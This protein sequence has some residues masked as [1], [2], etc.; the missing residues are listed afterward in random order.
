MSNYKGVMHKVLH[1]IVLL[2]MVT[3]AAIVSYWAGF[4]SHLFRTAMPQVMEPPSFS[5]QSE[6]PPEFM[7]YWEAW[8][9]IQERF[10]GQL[11]EAK[12]Q[13]YG[14]IRGMLAALGDPHT[15]FI[16]PPQREIE[17][18]QLQGRYGGIGADYIMEGGYLVVVAAREGYPASRAGILPGDII[19]AVDGKEVLGLSQDEIVALINGPVGT[20]VELTIWRRGE[21]ESLLFTLT[22]EEITA[23]TVAWEVKEEKIGYIQ[24]SLFSERT[25]DEVRQ[26]LGQLRKDG[27]TAIILDLRNNP[28]GLVNAAVDVASEFL[29]DGV[30]FY[31]RD[32][33]GKEETFPVRKGG[34]A[35][36]YPLVTLVNGGTASAAEI[37]AGA[38]QDRGRAILIGERTFG[39]GS[40]QSV[41][42][43]SDGSSIHVTMAHWF[44][45]EGHKIEGAGLSPDMEVPITPEDKEQGLDPQLEE[46]LKYLRPKVGSPT[47]LEGQSLSYLIMSSHDRGS[48]AW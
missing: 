26:A 48:R 34:L 44:T 7:V 5:P 33:Q 8:E 14:S 13:V 32:G 4:A 39:K 41:H 3:L 31:E 21:T 43:L 24:L 30:V 22:R 36:D 19:V 15:F 16:E 12:A 42:E 46:A 45:P 11:P 29:A 38:L 40:V 27:A 17:E 35:T 6:E 28:G 10:D 1:I 9:Q 47:P 23:P 18:A 2:L 25:R 37:V 20:E